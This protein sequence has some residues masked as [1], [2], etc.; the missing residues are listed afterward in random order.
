MN[1]NRMVRVFYAVVLA[2]ALGGSVTAAAHWLNVNW[3]IA[4]GPI[5][6]VELGG[7]VLMRYADERRQLGERALFAMTLSTAFASV[8]VAANV[9]GHQQVGLAAFFG[10]MSGLG[11]LVYLLI[12][13]AKRRDALRLAG[14]MEDTTPTY[15]VVQWFTHPGITRRARILAQAN[16]ATRLAEGPQ[17][18]TARL[19]RLASL[20]AAR[21]QVRAERRE[22]AI[23]K[24]V[25]ELIEESADPTL[26]A[27]AVHTYDPAA[28]AQRIAALADYD[29]YAAL[30]SGRLTPAKLAGEPTAAPAGDDLAVIV[31]AITEPPLAGPTPATYRPRWRPTTTRR[32]RRMGRPAPAI[33]VTVVAPERPTRPAKEPATDER[34]VA[35]RK[36]AK[37]AATTEQK[38]AALRT[39]N[40]AMTQ[41][42]VAARLQLGT[43]TVRRYWPRQ[44]AGVN[45]HDHSKEG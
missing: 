21:E 34:Q 45:G 2:T 20:A 5:A 24:A 1:T 4:L 23:A 35:G 36:A 19:G 26:A 42:D 30:L 37:P 25:R 11:Y 22:A 32:P 12:T 29:G 16:S 17:P 7:V 27:I 10:V 18:T 40:P 38:V 44:M 8:A 39:K 31:D 6:A 3:W 43:R 41:A 9:F 13:S 15:G 33:N 14:K 28:I